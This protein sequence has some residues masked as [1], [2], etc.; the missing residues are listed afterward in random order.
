M[1]HDQSKFIK[2][3]IHCTRAT[4]HAMLVPGVIKASDIK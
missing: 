3:Y 1:K 4:E 2:L